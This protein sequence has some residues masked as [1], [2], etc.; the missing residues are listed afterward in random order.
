MCA[1]ST[2]AG[3]VEADPSSDWAAQLAVGE[4]E[5]LVEDQHRPHEAPW[6]QELMKEKLSKQAAKQN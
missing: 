5:L 3:K 6:L 1:V 2:P 4:G